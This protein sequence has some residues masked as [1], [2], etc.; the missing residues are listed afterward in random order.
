MNG[1]NLMCILSVLICIFEA[2]DLGVILFTGFDC[3]LHFESYDTD[4]GYSTYRGSRGSETIDALICTVSRKPEIVR[5]VDKLGRCFTSNQI[6]RK[7]V[8]L[9]ISA[10]L[11]LALVVIWVTQ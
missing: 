2:F 11:F 6:A 10:F 3:V 9:I 4:S 8:T 1:E 5:R 7:V